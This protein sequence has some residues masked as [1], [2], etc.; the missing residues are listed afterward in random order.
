MQAGFCWGNLREGDSL[1]DP[2]GDGGIILK[3]IL[4]RGMGHGQD[5]PGSG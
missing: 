5:L 4:K 1:E 3:G 2:G